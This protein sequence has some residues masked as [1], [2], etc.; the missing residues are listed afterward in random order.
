MTNVVEAMIKDI[1]DLGWR[2]LQAVN[3]RFPDSPSPSPEWAPGPLLKSYERSKPPL[4]WPR[5]TDSL[6]PRCVI[7]TRS[8]ISRALDA[9]C[10]VIRL[11]TL[12]QA[13][14]RTSPTR[15]PRAARAW[16]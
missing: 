16:R 13:I 9:A 12:A 4:G 3:R 1:A 14:S 15:S 5:D 7:E 8:A 11:A 2:G 10:A 6:C